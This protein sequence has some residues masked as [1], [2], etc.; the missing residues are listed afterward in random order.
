MTDT[1]AAK[2]G[3]RVRLGC[4]ITAIERGDSAVTVHFR[5]FG[6]P[7]KLEAEYLVCS[8]P[9]AILKKIPVTARLAR[10]EGVRDPERRLR[11]AGAGGASVTHEV[12]E[13]GRAQHQPGNRRPGDVPGLPDGRRSARDGGVLMGSGRAGCHRR[14]G[15]AAFRRFYPGKS[16]HDRAGDRAQ[17]G[18]RPLGLRLRA[19]AVPAW[20]TQEFWPHIMEPVGR[21]HFAGSFA[22]NLPWGWTPPRARP[23][24]WRPRSTRFETGSNNDF[25]PPCFSSVSYPRLI[26][27][28]SEAWLRR[29]PRVGC[30]TL[31]G[32]T[33]FSGHRELISS[34]V[35]SART[36][37][38]SGPTRLLS[39]IA[40]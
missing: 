21:I 6:E 1:F 5:Q 17:L 24:A 11:L 4:P 8:I 39:T 25:G 30:Y 33:Y 38:P 14:R 18:E 9:L 29:S 37:P 10:V 22:D 40:L 13:R 26:L 31:C 7:A 35:R 20:P 19:D 12:L 28:S 16:A 15:V 27:L 23:T 32:G 3:E 36:W 34:T 2:L